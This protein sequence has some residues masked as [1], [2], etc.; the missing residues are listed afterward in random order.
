MNA[1][2]LAWRTEIAENESL[3]APKLK[4]ISFDGFIGTIWLTYDDVV[5]T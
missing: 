4:G 2:S 5:I 1:V 3:L